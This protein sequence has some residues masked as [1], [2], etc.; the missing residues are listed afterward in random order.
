MYRGLCGIRLLETGTR[1]TLK[2]VNRLCSSAPLYPLIHHMAIQHLQSRQPRSP[3]RL[4][5]QPELTTNLHLDDPTH[6]G[7]HAIAYPLQVRHRRPDRLR[8]LEISRSSTENKLFL[9]AFLDCRYHW[10]RHTHLLQPVRDS[11]SGNR[12]DRKLE[13]SV[14]PT[15]PSPILKL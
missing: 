7:E 3:F 13:S 4:A 15:S 8:N 2:I 10:S 9:E 1:L 12:S 14:G 5:S 11:T 6:R